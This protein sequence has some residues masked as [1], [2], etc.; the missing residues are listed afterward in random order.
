MV[1]VQL[2]RSRAGEVVSLICSGH[3]AFDNGQGLDL[4][5]AAV[6]ALT[7]A[8]GLGLTEILSDSAA[9]ECQDGYF[10]ATLRPGLCPDQAV[11]ARVLMDTVTGALLQMAEH[12]PG[13]I[14]VE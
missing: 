9:V 11:G 12:Y 5:C 8:L 14:S 1:S 6:S 2:G 10:S 3:A 13:F 4:V 7:G